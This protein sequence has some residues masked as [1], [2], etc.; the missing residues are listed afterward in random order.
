MEGLE[1]K[2]TPA[3]EKGIRL[4]KAFK[5]YFVAIAKEK[6]FTENYKVKLTDKNEVAQFKNFLE[7][8][9]RKF[10]SLRNKDDFMPKMLEEKVESSYNS[11][12]NLTG[13]V[14]RIDYV[15]DKYFLI[16]YKTGGTFG[17]S[18]E[19]LQELSFYDELLQR[20]KGINTDYYC[21]YYSAFDSFSKTPA[22]KGYFKTFIEPI[23]LEI[24]RCIKTDSWSKNV[25]FCKHCLLN[26][27]CGAKKQ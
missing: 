25:N 26:D 10:E 2:K 16:D 12:I 23:I 21:I 20:A 17:D 19:Y 11:T 22:E 5:E 24:D 13:I 18:S 15:E 27:Q 6:T 9:K 3:M 14:D 1:T 7:F 4:H 8:N